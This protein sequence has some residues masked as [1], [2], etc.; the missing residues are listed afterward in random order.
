MVFFEVYFTSSK[1]KMELQGLELFRG[2]LTYHRN[3]DFSQWEDIY[4]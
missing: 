4:V 1:K 2:N 3:L